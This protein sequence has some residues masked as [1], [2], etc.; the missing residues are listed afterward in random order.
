MRG[1]GLGPRS[2]V[3]LG[4]QCPTV[5][6]RA[7]LSR[8]R[9]EPETSRRHPQERGQL[10]AFGKF[11]PDVALLVVVRLRKRGAQGQRARQGAQV[12]VGELGSEEI[13]DVG[14]RDEAWG[15]LAPR[16][17]GGLRI[18][19]CRRC[20]VSVF[21]GFGTWPAVGGSARPL[22]GEPKVF[23]GQG[24]SEAFALDLPA[25]L[26]LKA[27]L[28]RRQLRWTSLRGKVLVTRAGLRLGVGGGAERPD[29]PA[30]G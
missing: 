25:G 27:G 23:P 20:L 26:L 6:L 16:L 30:R 14:D 11:G 9:K 5:L 21:L 17:E 10:R 22:W 1:M 29:L 4:H 3:P 13:V 2:G 15:G 7:G 18:Q 19:F 8:I 12:E 28:C 24:E